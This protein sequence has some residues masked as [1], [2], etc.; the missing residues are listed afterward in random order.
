MAM[1]DSGKKC[2]EIFK[3]VAKKYQDNKKKD[4]FSWYS[5]WNILQQERGLHPN[6][7]TNPTDTSVKCSLYILLRAFA[8]KINKSCSNILLFDLLFL[9][10]MR[11]RYNCKKKN[12][13]LFLTFP[14]NFLTASFDLHLSFFLLLL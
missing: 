8:L 10:L 4:T 3:Q 6:I 9:F 13:L 12:V 5:L 1:S 14:T 11:R 7:Q 2:L